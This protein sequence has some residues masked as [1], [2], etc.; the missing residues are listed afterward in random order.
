MATSLPHQC[1]ARATGDVERLGAPAAHPEYTDAFYRR[2]RAKNSV[3]TAEHSAAST[4]V[5]IDTW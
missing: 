3:R 2:L 4:S 1:C 5:V